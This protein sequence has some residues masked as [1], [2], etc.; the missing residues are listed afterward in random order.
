M[1]CSVEHPAMASGRSPRC[2]AQG[3]NQRPN[4]FPQDRSRL[5]SPTVTQDRAGERASQT[6]HPQ[7]DKRKDSCEGDGLRYF[8]VP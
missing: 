2:P 1:Q 3:R 5:P 4:G 6:D 8:L 7:Q